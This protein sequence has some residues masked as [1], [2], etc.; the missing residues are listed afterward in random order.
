MLARLGRVD[1]SLLAPV[2]H[3][4][5]ETQ[6]D[7]ALLRGR[8]AL[9]A[10]RTQLINAVRG[11]VKSAGGRVP[12]CTTDSFPRKAEPK[13]PAE[14]KLAVEPVL[15]SIA[16]L[17]EQ[18]QRADEQIA[19]LAEEKYPETKLLRQGKGIGPLIALAKPASGSGFFKIE[20]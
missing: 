17:S 13:I 6:S 3:R 20:T 19:K 5:A 1:V 8:N 16:A 2:R 14:L 10:A 12:K 15:K 7:F 18:I 4:R 9:V 11:L